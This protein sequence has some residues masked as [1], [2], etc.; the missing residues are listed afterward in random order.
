MSFIK[1]ASF[2]SFT[3]AAKQLGITPAAV[4]KNVQKLEDDLGVRLFQRTTRQLALTEEG[5]ILFER[6]R[7]PMDDLERATAAVTDYRNAVAGTL[8]VSCAAT[9]GRRMLAP[10]LPEFLARYPQLEVEVAMDDRFSDL[11]AEGYDVAIRGGNLPDSNM[12]ARRLMDITAAVYG[13][14]AYFRR[15]GEPATP[16]DLR[17]HNCIAMRMS[18]SNRLLPWEFEKDGMLFAPEVHG[19]L[20]VNDTEA[21]LEA[22]CAGHGIALLSDLLVKFDPR[23]ATLTRVLSDYRFPPRGLY[24][25]YPNRKH[26]PRK[27][28]AFVDFLVEK[29]ELQAKHGGSAPGEREAEGA[30]PG[31]TDMRVPARVRRAQPG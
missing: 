6:C 21:I 4:S 27:I 28:K 18:G 16:D 9:F 24:A 31:G 25:C 29:L 19:S 3:A 12:V 23:A 5:Q 22:V 11:I 8:R 1:T 14:P 26:L 30:P 20:I 7:D 2:G 10:C 17:K 15:Y 13:S